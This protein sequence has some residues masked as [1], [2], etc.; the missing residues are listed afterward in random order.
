MGLLIFCSEISEINSFN[1]LEVLR[2]NISLFSTF[3]LKKS[4]V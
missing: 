4:R 2:V 3:K 1:R